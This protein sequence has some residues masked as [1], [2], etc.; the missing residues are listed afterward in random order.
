[1]NV[2][3]KFSVHSFTAKYVVLKVWFW[4][5]DRMIEQSFQEDQITVMKRVQLDSS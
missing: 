4:V 2:N 1:M 5:Q 3:N